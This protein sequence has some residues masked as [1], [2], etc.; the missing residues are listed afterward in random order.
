MCEWLNLGYSHCASMSRQP[1][2]GI[3]MLPLNIAT[4]LCICQRRGISSELAK[5]VRFTLEGDKYIDIF[6]S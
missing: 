4:Q 5:L 6:L 1:Q 3:Y 2:N